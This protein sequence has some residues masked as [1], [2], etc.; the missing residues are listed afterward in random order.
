MLLL[1]YV[2]VAYLLVG[3]ADVLAV[4]LAFEILTLGPSGPGLLI[5]AIGFGGMVGAGASVLLAGRRRLGPA[6]AGALLAAGA[7]FALAGLTSHLLMALLLLAA[8]G[9]GKSYLEVAARTL[10]QR[11]V[12]DDVLARV[13]GLQ[14]GL[15][16]L[17][18]AVGALLVPLLVNLAGPRGAFVVAGLLLPLLA[19]FTWR[20]LLSI[21]AE[22]LAPPKSLLPLLRVPTFG[23]LPVPVVERVAAQCVAV[24]FD[25][26]ESVIRQGE[27]GEHFYVVDSGELTV[28]VDG[29]PRPSLGPGDSFGE[30]A[31][32][33]DLPRTASVT[34]T[35]NVRLWML[36]RATF[37]AAVTGSSRSA[38]TAARI[39]D[40][41]LAATPST[42]ADALDYRTRRR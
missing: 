3:M 42:T 22:A 1:G 33:R 26:G 18:M 8:A 15:M 36:D 13:F 9:A 40:V 10:L 37:L 19:A 24:E 14:E 23:H 29:Q 5:S 21:D 20:S 11:S 28:T 4:V 27:A 7:P 25:A 35:T 2:G 38:V 39:A 12:N 30:I 31:L 16:L 41:R 34:A 6:L 32:M 17:S